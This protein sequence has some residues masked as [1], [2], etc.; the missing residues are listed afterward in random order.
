MSEQTDDAIL[1]MLAYLCIAKEGEASL[2]RKVQVLDRFRLT[3][4]RIATVCGSS[5]QS[6]R[7]ARQQG[8][9]GRNA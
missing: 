2:V 4:A 5:V 9:K 3:D 1:L 8:K 7:N 6:V